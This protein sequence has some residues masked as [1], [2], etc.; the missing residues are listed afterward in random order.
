[1]IH[2]IEERKKEFLIFL[3]RKT[4][5]TQSP[6]ETWK[7]REKQT[8]LEHP[9]QGGSRRALLE[10][11][12]KFV[13]KARGRTLLYVTPV[14]EDSL[15]SL[16]FNGKP[17]SGGMADDTDHSNR[18]LLESLIG[19]TD[20]SDDLSLE[21]GHPVHIIYDGKIR[22][23]VKKT[24]HRDIPSQSVLCRRPKSVCPND[25]P[26]FCL[27]FLKFGSTSKSGNFD[28]LSSL[29][30]NMNQSESAADDPAVLKES[31][32]FMGMGIG[33]YIEIFR[34]FSEKKIP[35]G[36]ADEIS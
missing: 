30:E 36:S 27:D 34:S 29:E 35:D 8:G 33:G 22:D 28:D 10:F 7:K 15:V 20:R 21:V 23:I 32:D 25:I 6:F 5:L 13:S 26:F 9:F 16:V 24:I 18:I 4:A 1:L 11:S 14:P 3:L 12:Q 17:G 31:V 2:Q 19:I